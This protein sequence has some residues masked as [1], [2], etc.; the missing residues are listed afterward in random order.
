[1]VT[2][3][4]ERFGRDNSV[5]VSLPQPHVLSVE[6]N[7]VKRHN[8]FDVPMWDE[9]SAFCPANPHISHIGSQKH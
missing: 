5:H 7:R 9:V 4:L 2:S 8:A 6:L 3:L 1:M